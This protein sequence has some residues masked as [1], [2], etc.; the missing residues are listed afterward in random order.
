M[1]MVY[2][3]VRRIC[4]NCKHWKNGHCDSVFSLMYKYKRTFDCSCRAWE[5]EQKFT[6]TLEA[7]RS[8]R[9]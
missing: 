9:K 8:A 6:T 7:I 2:D 5:H 1:V 4:L 3:E